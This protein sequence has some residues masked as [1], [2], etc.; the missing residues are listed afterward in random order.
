[1]DGNCA[2]GLDCDD[3]QVCV[4]PEPLLCYLLTDN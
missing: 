4:V 2:E 3:S 1:M